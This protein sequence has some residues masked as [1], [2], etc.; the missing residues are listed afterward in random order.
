MLR[1]PE[2][3]A[4]RPRKRARTQEPARRCESIAVV[5]IAEL[6]LSVEMKRRT[7][8]PGARVLLGAFA[9]EAARWLLIAGC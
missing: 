5:D 7:V 1:T 4:T 2:P 3:L 8:T 9:A 6:G